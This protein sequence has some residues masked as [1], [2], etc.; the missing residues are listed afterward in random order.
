MIPCS[1]FY[2][3]EVHL[4]YRDRCWHDGS[5]LLIELRLGFKGLGLVHATSNRPQHII[6]ACLGLYGRVFGSSVQT[7]L[8]ISPVLDIMLRFLWK[9]Y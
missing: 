9:L 7:V 2:W 8:R 4:A 6:D 1:H 3:V 5:R